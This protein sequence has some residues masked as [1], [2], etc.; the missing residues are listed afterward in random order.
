MNYSSLSHKNILKYDGYSGKNI[1]AGCT[2]TFTIHYDVDLHT[3][4]PLV[5]S[6]KVGNYG[7]YQDDHHGKIWDNDGHIGK[8]VDRKAWFDYIINNTG[9]YPA[10]NISSADNDVTFITKSRYLRSMTREE[11]Q[12]IRTMILVQK[13]K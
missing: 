9:K 8:Q 6:I 11:D 7:T 4:A 5:R 12:R 13:W 10:N 2:M 1:D 3:N